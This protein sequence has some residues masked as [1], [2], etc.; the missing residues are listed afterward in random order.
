[1]CCMRVPKV[2]ALAFAATFYTTVQPH[3]LT[4]QAAK[5]EISI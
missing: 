5:I 1:M 2:R 3:V 4:L